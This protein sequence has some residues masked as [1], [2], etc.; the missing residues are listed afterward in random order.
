MNKTLLLIVAGVVAVIVVVV[1]G[2]GTGV[3]PVPGVI[4]NPLTGAKPP[5]HSAR[6]YPSDTLAYAWLSLAPSGGQ[7]NDAKNIWDRSNEIPEF[8]TLYDEFK[9]EFEED[10]ESDFEDLKEWAGPDISGAI[11]VDDWDDDPLAALTIGVRNKGKAEDFLE[12][13]LDY[14][15]RE[16]GADFESDSYEGFDTWVDEYEEQA[17]GLS[18]DL[19][20][21][22]TTQDFL[23]D[24][25]DGING[26]LDET[27]ADNESFQAAR[28]ALPERRFASLY[29]D[30][31][32][33]WE[34]VAS[35][36][37]LDDGPSGGLIPEWIA[38]SSSWGDRSVTAELVMPSLLDHSLDFP[39]LKSPAKLLPEDT[40]LLVSASFDPD[41]DN[42]RETLQDETISDVVGDDAIDDLND[43]VE[44]IEYQLDASGLP[45]ATRRSGFDFFIDLGI[46]VVD[47][48]TGVDLEEDLFDHLQGDVS[49]AVWDFYLDEYGELEEGDPLSLVALLSYKGGGEDGLADTIEELQEFLE[50][51]GDVRFESVDVGADRDA[52]VLDIDVDYSPGYVLND[53][54]LIFASTED[55]LAGTVELQDGRGNNLDSNLEYQRVV[56]HLPGDKHFLAYV[57]LN[58]IIR[59]ANPEAFEID[60]DP[61]SFDVDSTEVDGH[62]LWEA[63]IGSAAASYTLGKRDEEGRDRYAAVLTLFPE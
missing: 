13:W 37:G 24:V 46:E 40:L 55:S 39:D 54:Y 3:V 29:V 63:S 52:Q 21:F 7:F 51:E 59:E 18:G 19:L 28:A 16:E 15:D 1:A 56:G 33:V 44:S 12:D 58:E 10:V 49:L 53:G 26:D 42:W 23:E 17:Y 31:E 50:D 38:A 45:T 41:L 4:W 62:A 34:Q 36:V 14:M 32:T 35:E 6:Y 61:Y 5:E 30:S 20:V 2:V 25:I 27:L 43:A 57:N 60:V 9:E 22:A 11:V 48:V 8:E 47:E